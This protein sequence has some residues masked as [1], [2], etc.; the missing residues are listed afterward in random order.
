HPALHR[1]D[2][3]QSADGRR[4][5]PPDGPSRSGARA[6]RMVA[7][8]RARACNA[9]ALHLDGITRPGRWLGEPD[10]PREQ[11]LQRHARAARDGRARSLRL[12]AGCAVAA[13]VV[14]LIGGF[15]ISWSFILPVRE[16]HVFLSEVAEGR[17]GGTI[18]VPNRDEFGALAERMNWM[19]HELHRLDDEQRVAAETLRGLN[20]RL[21]LARD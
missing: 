20:E 12:M 14:A 19:S 3:G 6:R 13:V 18:V 1:D 9:D 5:R 8:D 11:S 7:A 10:P 21:A 16:A 15:V 2:R 17:F 4:D